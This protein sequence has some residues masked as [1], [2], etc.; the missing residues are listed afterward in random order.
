VLSFLSKK[1]SKV[2]EK[3]PDREGREGRNMMWVL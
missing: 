2:D 1:K 3:E